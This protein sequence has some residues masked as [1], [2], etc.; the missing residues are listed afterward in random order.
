MVVD[1]CWMLMDTV[2]AWVVVDDCW[3]LKDTLGGGCFVMALFVDG[4]CG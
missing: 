2:C 4:Y 3:V 1:D